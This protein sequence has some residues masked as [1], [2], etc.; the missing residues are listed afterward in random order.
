MPLPL[1]AALVLGGARVAATSAARRYGAAALTAGAKYAKPVIQ[2]GKQMADDAAESVSKYFK[3]PEAPAAPSK[4]DFV[5]DS[6]G[7]VSRAG[8]AAPKPS[9]GSTITVDAGGTARMPNYPVATQGSRAVTVAGKKTIDP[10]YAATPSKLKD[11]V[12]KATTIASTA[13]LA[14]TPQKAEAPTVDTGATVTEEKAPSAASVKVLDKGRTVKV[15]ASAPKKVEAE[16]APAGASVSSQNNVAAVQG[17][18]NMDIPEHEQMR[19]DPQ[20]EGEIKLY[21]A[22]KADGGDGQDIQ[23][24]NAWKK[25]KEQGMSVVKDGS[26]KMVRTGSGGFL[27]SRY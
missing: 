12:G 1:A 24:F 11:M 27:T 25:I 7:T 5:V 14:G 19:P 8:Q 20:F 6:A 9:T 22:Y 3:K 18:G 2:K 23:G 15:G 26:G 10:K 17:S 21:E 13:Q 4:P 16:G